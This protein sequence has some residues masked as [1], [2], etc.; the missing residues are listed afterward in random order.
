[1]TPLFIRVIMKTSTK[2]ELR[3]MTSYYKI[4][5]LH[6]IMGSGY[7]QETAKPWKISQNNF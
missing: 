2:I 5:H 4:A 6:Y 1:M 3:Q 7:G